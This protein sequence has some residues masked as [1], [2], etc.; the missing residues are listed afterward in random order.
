FLI[1][2]IINKQG[3]SKLDS[4]KPHLYA[5]LSAVNLYLGDYRS[6]I[7]AIE[8]A[9]SYSMDYIPYQININVLT[10]NVWAKLPDSYQPEGY[11]KALGYLKKASSLAKIYNSK[12]MYSFTLNN[13][14]DLYLKL[15]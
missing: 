13:I 12:M 2:S 8:K 11:R 7:T 6:A 10:S 5:K 3:D 4:L 14:A 9:Q 15:G 1:N